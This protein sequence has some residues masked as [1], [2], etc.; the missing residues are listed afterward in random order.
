MLFRSDQTFTIHPRKGSYLVVDKKKGHLSTSS[1]GKATYTISPYQDAA[2]KGSLKKA[3]GMLLEN[4][5]SHSKGIAVIH[6]IDNNILLGPEAIETPDRESTETDR[7]TADTLM[8]IQHEV[9][10]EISRSDIITYFSGVR[11]ASYE[12]DFVVRQ[13]IR[14]RNIFEMAAIQSPGVTAAP[15]I[16]VDIVRWA[17]DYLREQG[18]PV[19]ENE[20]FRPKHRF[21]PTVREMPDEERD[22]L[23]RRDPDYGEI[24]CRCEEVSRGEIRD[25]LR[26]SLPVYTL[27]AVKRRV[28]PGMGRCQGG[29]CTPEVL[30]LIAE[31]S[32]MKPEEIAKSSTGS[33]ILKGP[34]RPREG[35]G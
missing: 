34:I 21:P 22:A 7:Q 5:H 16:A 25:A 29:F 3:V 27:D 17:V 35:E 11:S 12:E 32:G 10:P 2:V 15:A 6:T 28:R 20:D 8:Q 4:I 18:L 33:E 13:G 14:T 31:A 30:R 9:V 23:I 24:V 1:M 26:S 19:E